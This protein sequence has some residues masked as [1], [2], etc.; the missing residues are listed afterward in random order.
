MG[1]HHRQ[2]AVTSLTI[3]PDG[4]LQ[5]IYPG[6]DQ[7]VGTPGVTHLTLDAFAPRRQAVEFQVEMNAWGERGLVGEY[8]MKMGD[9][10]YLQYHDVDFGDGAATFHVEVSSENA[11]LRNG[12][13]E[14]RLDNPVGALIGEVKIEPTGGR[15]TYRVLTTKVLP[16]AKGVHDLCLVARG[17][18]T[19]TQRRL[20]NITSFGFTRR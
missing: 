17:E 7:G 9:G 13:L 11:A 20:F 19:T 6:H 15:T 1:D 4:S 16:S 2:V 12:S 5:P 10:G 8:Q 18:G 14:I 3:L